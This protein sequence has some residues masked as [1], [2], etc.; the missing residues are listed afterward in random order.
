MVKVVPAIVKPAVLEAETVLAE[1]EYLTVP[2][3]VPLAPDVIVTHDGAELA[4]VQ[5]QAP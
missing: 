2:L 1:T 4:A 3:P 5:L